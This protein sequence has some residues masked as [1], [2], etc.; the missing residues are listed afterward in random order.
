MKKRTSTIRYV[1]IF[2]AEKVHESEES[3]KRAEDYTTVLDMDSVTVKKSVESSDREHRQLEIEEE[4]NYKD[5]NKGLT[6][7]SSPPAKSSLPRK[8]IFTRNL[9][10]KEQISR[11]ETRLVSRGFFQTERLK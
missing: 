5:S 10:E 1:R 4:Q 8:I 7:H 2:H 9:N 11:S 3:P 6:E